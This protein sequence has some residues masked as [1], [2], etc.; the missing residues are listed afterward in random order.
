[1]D[2]EITTWASFEDMRVRNPDIAESD[3]DMCTAALEDATT[4]INS[5]LDLAG[6]DYT[7]PDESMLARLN[8]VCCSVAM[9]RATMPTNGGAPVSQYGIEAGVFSETFRFSDS[10]DGGLYLTKQEKRML[11]IIGDQT[12]EHVFVFADVWGVEDE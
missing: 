6:I 7:D 11:G 1:M 4:L 3:E 9:R 5:E 8:T 12:A 2:D 10:A